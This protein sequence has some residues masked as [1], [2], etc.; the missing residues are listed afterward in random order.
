MMLL[1]S[2]GS[3]RSGRSSLGRMAGSQAV[4]EEGHR[5]YVRGRQND[6]FPKGGWKERRGAK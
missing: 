2:P 4:V 5:M 1:S 3:S 6:P